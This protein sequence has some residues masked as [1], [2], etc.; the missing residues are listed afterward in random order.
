M[1]SLWYENETKFEALYL[2]C[3]GLTKLVS[4]IAYINNEIWDKL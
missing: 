4:N 1:I 2:S 3:G